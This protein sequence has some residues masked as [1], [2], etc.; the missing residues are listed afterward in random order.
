[1][2]RA[3]EA[4]EGAEEALRSNDLAEAINQQSKALDALRNG[5]K[6]LS[7]AVNDVNPGQGEPGQQSGQASGQG[8][9]PLGRQPGSSGMS[10]TGDSMLND[11]DVYRR[12]RDL[13]DEIR[14]RSGEGARSDI[15]REYLER[16]LDRF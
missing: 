16:L 10:E 14:R 13:L 2:E 12:A 15:E 7:D 8:S 3:D 4:M 11:E 5:V 9:D 1:V 6:A